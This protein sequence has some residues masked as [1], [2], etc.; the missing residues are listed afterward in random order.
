MVARRQRAWTAP[1]EGPFAEPDPTLEADPF[2]T[3]DGKRLYYV[4]ARHDPDNDD[5]GIWHVDREPD[6]RWGRPQR[7]PEPVNSSG[8]ELLPRQ[9]PDG[10]L[11]FGSSRTGDHCQGDICVATRAADGDWRVE[12]VGPPIST[13]ANEY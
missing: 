12:N 6:G 7:L 9:T 5:L 3:F 4:S 2:V 1:V 10:R 13:A 11:Y 8:A